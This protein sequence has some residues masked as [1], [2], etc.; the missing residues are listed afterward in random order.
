M[1]V[2]ILGQQSALMAIPL[3]GDT[4]S[5]L[6]ASVGIQLPDIQASANVFAGVDISVSLPSAEAQALINAAA[7]IAITPPSLN[8]DASVGADFNFKLGQLQVFADL[9]LYLQ[10]LGGSLTVANYQGT[11]GDFSAEASQC[12]GGGNSDNTFAIVLSASDTQSV[13]TLRKIFGIG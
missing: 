11:K 8:I 3:L 6:N 9:V 10:G 7:Q 1:T 5:A 2:S 4:C 12:I 13:E